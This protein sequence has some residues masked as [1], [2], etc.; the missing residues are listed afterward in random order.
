MKK[1]SALL[2][3]ICFATPVSA[4]S[5]YVTTKKI[6]TVTTAGTALYN[7]PEFE[8]F[9]VF[10][11]ERGDYQSLGMQRPYEKVDYDLIFRGREIKRVGIWTRGLWWNRQLFTDRAVV[12]GQTIVCPIDNIITLEPYTFYDDCYFR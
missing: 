2:L 3:G 4:Q 6:F 8:V 5:E 10:S 1:I 9:A 11:D 7:R 12:G